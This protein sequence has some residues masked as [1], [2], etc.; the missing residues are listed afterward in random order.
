MD[1]GI[2]STI[3]DLGY[4]YSSPF[5]NAPNIIL[6]IINPL[7]PDNNNNQVILVYIN[8]DAW[9]INPV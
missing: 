5:T 4:I 9:V 2:R 8:V 1:S 7:D 3:D 6:G